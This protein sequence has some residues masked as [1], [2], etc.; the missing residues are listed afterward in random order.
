[1]DYYAVSEVVFMGGSLIKKGGHNILEPALLG[2]PVVFGPYM[3]NFRDITEQ[4]LKNKASIQVQD[5]RQ[6]YL[7]L[8]NLF[9]NPDKGAVL[10]QNAQQLILKNQGATGMNMKFIKDILNNQKR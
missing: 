4:F 5:S 8:K 6:L 7:Q 9:E 10:T 1:M 3:F 2:K